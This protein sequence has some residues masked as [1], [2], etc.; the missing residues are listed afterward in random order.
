MSG[1]LAPDST[2]REE[3]NSLLTSPEPRHS[4]KLESSF[5]ERTDSASS[6]GANDSQHS[7][8]Q[9][10]APQRRT[11]RR[12]YWLVPVAAVSLFFLGLF[13]AFGHYAFLSQLEN[14]TVDNQ[15]WT[16]RYSLA[17]AF[18]FKSAL[19]ASI[20]SALTQH[21]W[22]ALRRPARGTRIQLIDAMFTTD[23][24]LFSFLTPG[25]WSSAVGTGL[26]AACVWLMP[27]T[28]LVAPTALTVGTLVVSTPVDN[29]VVP[30]LDWAVYDNP[31]NLISDEQA[32]TLTYSDYEDD[33][34]WPSTASQRLTAAVADTGRQTSWQS[35]CGHNCTYETSFMAPSWQCQ[36]RDIYTYPQSNSSLWPTNLNHTINVEIEN[37]Y[38]FTS[39]QLY[40][41]YLDGPRNQLFIG[42][43]SGLAKYYYD[44]STSDHIAGKTV[45]EVYDIH[46]F[47]CQVANTSYTIQVDYINSIQSTAVLKA[48]P[49]ETFAISA[50]AWQGNVINSESQPA[51]QE[52]IGMF[53]PVINTLNGT[54]G[55]VQQNAIS[56]ST[57]MGLITSLIDSPPLNLSKAYLSDIPWLPRTD[58]G[59]LLQE[60]SYNLSI[61][62][63]SY[64][65][66]LVTS[67]TTVTCT[68]YQTETVWKF[69]RTPLVTAYSIGL[70]VTLVCLA[71]GG[72]SL[73]SNG[74]AH[75]YSFSSVVRTTRNP[76][77]SRLVEAG[78]VGAVP[79]SEE[80]GK[81]RL[82]FLEEGD[83]DDRGGSS[84]ES[85]D[86]FVLVD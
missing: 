62:L 14:T 63:M 50:S 51:L 15:T 64:P 86:G 8:T 52:V 69:D 67:D 9:R 1:L 73:V 57:N 29:C 60:L 82:K 20:S 61:S 77:L 65:E 39:G 17:L 34:Y 43:A 12:I 35:P 55:Y 21:V 7:K 41:A 11:K 24:S 71:V 38:D 83:F 19:A 18:I 53:L 16:L 33:F 32:Q 85:R 3:R 76:K 75:D 6:L 25:L 42:Y 30:T 27:L 84:M 54:I 68:K 36:Q 13:A 72:Y 23:R 10:D 28:A 47:T 44:G 46:E 74:V 59:P 79:L 40:Q 78:D 81:Q 4:G 66:L 45:G 49:F 31:N 80:V 22:F 26:M 2:P 48:D 58:L 37:S 70:F 5:A 56:Y